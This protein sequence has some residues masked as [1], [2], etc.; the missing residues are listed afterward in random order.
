MKRAFAAIA[1]SLLLVAA[2]CSQPQREVAPKTHWLRF[3]DGAGGIPTLNPHLFNGTT[4]HL[5]GLLTMAYL[6]RYD[7]QGRPQPELATEFPTQQNGGIS[8]DGRTI[9][10]HLRR[11]VRWSDG[12]PFTADDVVFST[13]VVLDPQNDELTREGWDLI[14]RVSE[15]DAYTVVYH[16]KQP[17]A[18]FEPAFFGTGLAS[19]CILP[20]H[21]LEHEPN[22]NH[23]AYN[24]K[25][26][27]IGPFR[28]TSFKRDE[29]I[30]L[31]ANP[32][33]FRGKP[34]LDRVTFRIYPTRDALFEAL[35][36]GEVDLWPA[37]PPQ[38]VARVQGIRPLR[39]IVGPSSFW[40]ALFFN[41]EKPPENDRR[42][43]E[44]ARYA[45][46]RS[47]IIGEAINGNG[48][49]QDGPIAPSVA[50][51][52]TD[53][54]V[55]PFD[56][57]HARRLL[58]AAGWQ[59]SPD[60][61]RRKNGRKLMLA[62]AMGNSSETDFLGTMLR[63]QL[64]SVGIALQV[65]HYPASLLFASWG[66][67]GVVTRGEWNVTS[68]ALQSD[69]NGSLEN[70]F[71]CSRT[72]PRGQNVARYCNHDLD[73]TLYRYTLT[74]DEAERRRMLGNI[75][76]ELVADAPFIT[77]WAWKEGYTFSPRLEGYEPGAMAPLGDPMELDI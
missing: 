33:Y 71:A 26:I 42:V 7:A 54:P 73:V 38:Y 76:R 11:G 15:P 17:Y 32:Y 4:V 3:A 9:V 39:T 49:F 55:T 22:I 27:G 47:R 69:P 37:L 46:D 29:A 21:L 8:P 24:L 57:A 53:L 72:P 60:G 45:I 66:Q 20:K 43:R 25:P 77:L 1:A 63:G 74:Y 48:V 67:H 35:Q 31:E 40:S 2:A 13:H 52:P 19:P 51:A 64:R 56:P 58:D 75:E 41:V 70:L 59:M 36:T 44:A 10:F 34:K 61:V 6:F 14:D 30:E 50:V 23:A 18:L 62:L 65:R 28:V 68:F 16:L 5:I 12:A